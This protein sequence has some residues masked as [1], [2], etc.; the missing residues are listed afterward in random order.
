MRVA[1]LGLCVLTVVLIV[2]LM[3]LFSSQAQDSDSVTTTSFTVTLTNSV[4]IEFQVNNPGNL[5]I[6]RGAG[7]LQQR[8]HQFPT[9]ITIRIWAVT[10]YQISVWTTYADVDTTAGGAV[11]DDIPDGMLQIDQATFT[12]AVG[13]DVAGQPANDITTWTD[14]PCDA[15]NTGNVSCTATDDLNLFTGVNTYGGT[16][17]YQ[18]ATV[19]LRIDLDNFGDNDAGNIYTFQVTFTVTETT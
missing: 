8:Y 7:D 1:K 16:L 17:E 11:E 18:D 14:L 9:D 10:D 12:P 3:L 4:D 15:N 6:Q 5:D 2:S 13:D 19:S